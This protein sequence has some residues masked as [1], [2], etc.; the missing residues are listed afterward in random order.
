M[1]EKS[2]NEQLAHLVSIFEKALKDAEDF[3]RENNLEF[4]IAP[5][6]GMGGTYAPDWDSSWNDSGCSEN[7]EQ[8]QYKWNASSQS[9]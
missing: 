5:T 3:A 7:Y 6:Y 1:N 9:C 2:K 4:R 8:R